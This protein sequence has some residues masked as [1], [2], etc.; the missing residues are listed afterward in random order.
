MRTDRLA[1]SFDRDR[2]TKRKAAVLERV[3]LYDAIVSVVALKS[4][5]KHEYRGVCPLPTCGASSFTLNTKK[6]LFKCFG[7]DASGTNAIDFVMARQKL[8]FTEAIELLESENG[9]SRLAAS[10]APAPRPQRLDPATGLSVPVPQADDVQRDQR[11]QRLWARAVHDPAIDQYLRGRALVPCAEYGF[12]DPAVNGG[13]PAALK[14]VA[15][16]YHGIEQRDFPAMIVPYRKPDGTV[17]AVHR[18]YLKRVTGGWEKAGTRK[19]KMHL[20]P[21]A[22]AL[23]MLCEPAEAMTAGEGLETSM[24]NMQLWRRAGF[25]YGSADAM[26]KVEPPFLCSDL[27]IGADWNKLRRTGE[28]AAWA[29]KKAFST[30]GRHIGIMVPNMR[31]LDKADFNDVLKEQR[32]AERRSAGEAA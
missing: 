3:G 1:V 25:A 9:L 10:P 20:G 13:W 12:G 5:A 26:A 14:F 21:R 8:E 15:A 18:T 22:G 17:V 31:H 23:L 27:L 6:G 28:R 2:W 11:V 19:D 32:A 7:C 30:G 4:V 16:C 24:S 29:A